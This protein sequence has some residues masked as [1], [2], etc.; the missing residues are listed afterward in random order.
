MT[1]LRDKVA[2]VTGGASG[3]GAATARRLAAEGATVII[4]DIQ[5]DVGRRLSEELDCDFINHDVTDE[6]QWERLIA[7]AEQLY[8]AL[9]ILVNNA[10]VEGALDLNNPENT[11][12]SDWRTVH[13]VNVDGVFLG[14]RAAIPAM[15]RA[16]G[17]AIVN[18]SSIAAQVAEPEFIA[19]GASKAAVHHLTRSVALHCAKDG[20]KI[21]CNSVHPATILTPMLYRFIS[22]N[23]KTRGISVD[24]VIC[25][26]RSA[27]PQGEFPEPDDVANA[28]LFLASDD[29]RHI[30][31]LAM[32]VDGGYTAG[33]RT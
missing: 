2:I 6:A 19:Y 10:G 25:E 24:Q 30:T 3:L 5:D 28:V 12:L 27:I 11:Q 22:T 32:T 13:R 8:G 7:K 21:R 18:M 16:G 20:S 15:R 26:L 31:G 4:T 23:A 17:G 14:C 1:R 9:H 33:L 29:A